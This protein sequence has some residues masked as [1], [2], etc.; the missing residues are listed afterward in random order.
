ML[1]VFFIF[2]IILLFL[3]CFIYFSNIR[4]SLNLIYDGIHIYSNKK[5]NFKA[6]IYVIPFNIKNLK[7]K[8]LEIDL[9][10]VKIC[11][12]KIDARKIYLK[13][14]ERIDIDNLRFDINKIRS[15]DI[16]SIKLNKFD[17]RSNLFF[18]DPITNVKFIGLIYSI[19]YYIFGKL[20]FKNNAK[21]YLEIN[22]IDEKYLSFF[23][24]DKLLYAFFDSYLSFNIRI[25]FIILSILKMRG[26]K[27]GTSN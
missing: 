24:R 21:V 11:F 6:Y 18:I 1:L 26:D 5:I 12:F 8:V 14:L 23:E 22:P 7:F 16:E 2:L 3:F 4:V 10:F 15:I 13:L 27:N 20:S 25:K 19:F 17:F 9:R